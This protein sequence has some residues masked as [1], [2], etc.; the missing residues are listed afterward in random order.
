VVEGDF[1]VRFSSYRSEGVVKAG[2]TDVTTVWPG[3]DVFELCEL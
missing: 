2:C 3:G 1:D